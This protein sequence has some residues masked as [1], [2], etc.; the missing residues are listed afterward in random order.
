MQY[1]VDIETSIKNQVLW[2]PSGEQQNV[3]IKGH[4]VDGQKPRKKDQYCV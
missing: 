2:K 3:G 4:L 1:V